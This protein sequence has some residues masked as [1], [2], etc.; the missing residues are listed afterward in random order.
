MP[1]AEAEAIG[2]AANMAGR[3][4]AVDHEGLP[5]PVTA[6]LGAA[7]C[8]LCGLIPDQRLRARSRTR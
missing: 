6:L 4:R 1:S 3:D 2:L 7:L 5:M 8:I